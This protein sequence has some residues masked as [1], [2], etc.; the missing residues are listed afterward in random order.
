MSPFSIVK[1]GQIPQAYILRISGLLSKHPMLITG[2]SWRQSR[3]NKDLWVCEGLR[4]K[5]KKSKERSKTILYSHL[6]I[7]SL[8]DPISC[9]DIWCYLWLPN[10][11]LSSWPSSWGPHWHLN[12]YHHLVINTNNSHLKHV[13]QKNLSSSSTSASFMVFFKMVLSSTWP[14]DV[15]AIIL[16]S[17]IFLIRYQV[18]LIL[19]LSSFSN[20]S[21]S[22]KFQ[23]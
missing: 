15:P 18:L 12:H 1:Q 20:P 17:S 6:Y 22:Y 19:F 13:N 2:L 3:D 8:S 16:G 14:C 11:Y 4:E 23:L 5:L 10:P 7:F 21:S 9:H